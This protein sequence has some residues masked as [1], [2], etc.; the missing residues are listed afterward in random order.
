M[1]FYNDSVSLICQVV[2]L[3]LSGER[4]MYTLRSLTFKAMLRQEIAWFENKKNSTGALTVRLASDA[5][6]AKGVSILTCLHCKNKNRLVF[7]N[8]RV[9]TL[10]A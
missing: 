2:C 9:V 4:L 3:T 8:Y 7:F 10:A 6:R 1:Y 5:S